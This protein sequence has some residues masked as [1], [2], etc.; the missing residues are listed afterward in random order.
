[1]PQVVVGAA[2]TAALK[3]GFA[4]LLT[5]AFVKAFAVNVALFAFAGYLAKS[6]GAGFTAEASGRLATIRSPIETRRIVV[7]E[8]RVSGPLVA[9]FFTDSTEQR[10]LT[11]DTVIPPLV[12]GGTSTVSVRHAASFYDDLGVAVKAPTS[13]LT[14]TYTALTKVGSAPAAGQYSVSATGVYSFNDADRGK[15]ARIQYRYTA[16][17]VERE[18]HWFVIPLSHGQVAEIGEVFLNGEPVGVL[19]AA[20][21]ATTGQF[22]QHVRVKK[23]LGTDAQTADADLIAASAGRWSV[24]DRGRGVAY[25]IVALKR[26][27][28]VFP[29]GLPNIQAQVRGA[30]FEDTRDAV[31]RWTNNPALILR[32]YLRAAY[33]LASAADEVTDSLVTAAANICEERVA[34]AAHVVEFSANAAT[35]AITF[36]SP[37][38]TFDLGDK[39][40]VSNAG[41]GL[42]GGLS[43]ATDY[44]VI[45]LRD[46]TD[47]VQLATSYANA[48]AGT[49][50]DI[51]TAGTGTHSISHVDQA[52]YTCDGTINL[53]DKPI[54]IIA[55]LLTSMAGAA[56]YSMG[57]WRVFAGAY[58][59]PVHS[60]GV[61]D[62][63][64]DLEVRARTPRKDLFNAV[65]GTYVSP[66]KSWQPGDFPPVKNALYASQDGAEI[67]RD[68]ELP[69]TINVVRAQRIAKIHLEKSR[70]QIVC[71]GPYKFGALK[72]AVWDTIN[73]T[74][75]ELGWSS[76][77]FRVTEWELAENGRGVQLS[78]QEDSAAS[79]QWNAGEE[80]TVDP[81]PDTDLPN[82]FFVSQPGTPMATEELYETT[83]SAGVKARV[84]LTCAEAPDAFVQGYQ[85]EYKLSSQ[86]QWVKL[87]MDNLGAARAV[88][89]DASP[90][91]YDFR[92]AAVNTL[93]VQSL[94]SQVS[95]ITVRGLT[96]PPADVSGFA[97]R[98]VSGQ[99]MATLVQSSDLDV[100]IG[101]RLVL[102]WS[103]L[104]S[105]ATW[106][107]GSLLSPD[108]WP[109]DSVSVFAPL[110]PGT[111]MAKFRDSTGNYSTNAA[112]FVVTEAHMT[113]FTTLGTATEH[114][115]FTG[116][117]VNVAAVDGGIQ[118]V[119]ATLWDDL[120]AIDSVDTID[121]AGG[122]V[123]SGSYTFANRIDLGSVVTVRLFPNIK[124]FGLDTEDLWDSRTDPIDSWG[125]VDGGVIE[126]AE[127]ALEVRLT[128]DD[129]AGA[130]A[131]GPWHALPG[132]ADYAARAFEFRVQFSS[133][134]VVHNRKVTEIAVA[135]KQPT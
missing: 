125:L 41:G 131:W 132:Q 70:Q 64:G 126:D 16:V 49:A 7:G 121:A 93:L 101:G 34:M 20:G 75:A 79:Y 6:K 123:P 74:D 135:A 61:G 94:Y 62:L 44:Y 124:G 100:R 109:G 105:G 76:K 37:D 42:P 95:G 89:D 133:G 80:T 28:N 77:V 48:L 13:G 66:F 45:R 54:D 2:L 127:A 35:D 36:A 118:L 46:G 88:L 67:A 71:S 114:P 65:R 91:I 50:I 90:G 115:A 43:A 96:V 5:L 21:M 73:V 117:K 97:V 119:G 14:Y 17:V 108:G 103:P 116:V 30:L 39:V 32:G 23:Y 9:Y 112:S 134:N 68:I 29:T 24:T 25:I 102:R 53:G 130:P 92:V 56:V 129:P 58:S 31:T 83:G 12:T 57:A 10:G 38:E 99:G 85:F 63:R 11:E 111:Y 55:Q 47:K 98:V 1:M 87:P 40:Q 84:V 59:T 113:G 122:I 106:N 18:W 52:R 60:F 120:P 104:T 69:Y 78:Y 82:P 27:P 22:A 51:T 26:S 8:A 4:N 81:A 19:D 15:A 33:G 110:L 3:V 86:A 128:D 72:T 107:D